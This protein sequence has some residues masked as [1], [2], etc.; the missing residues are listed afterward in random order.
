MKNFTLLLT[1]GLLWQSS[2]AQF[3]LGNELVSSPHNNWSNATAEYCGYQIDSLGNAPLFSNLTTQYDGNN[4]VVYRYLDYVDTS[5]TNGIGT[6]TIYDTREY[7][8]YNTNEDI[9]SYTYEYFDHNTSVWIMQFR[10]TY[11]Y[12]IVGNVTEIIYEDWFGGIYNYSAQKYIYT[13]DSGG[14]LLIT[15]KILQQW[16]IS[17]NSYVNDKKYT[18]TYNPSLVLL[19]DNE[20][21]WNSS[22]S[23]WPSSPWTQ[24]TYT[25]GT[26]TRLASKTIQ[27][28][29]GNLRQ[30]L[31]SYTPLGSLTE[32][33]SQEKISNVW[34]N[35]DRTLTPRDGSERISSYHRELWS[36]SNSAWDANGG[37]N[38]YTYNSNNSLIE[39]IS[40]NWINNSWNNSGRTTYTLDANE[41]V[42]R[43]DSYIW[44]TT[45][46]QWRK[47][48]FQVLCSLVTANP[49]VKSTASF[50]V[51][52]NPS[53]SQL[54]LTT[55][56]FGNYRLLSTSGQVVKEGFVNQQTTI[57]VQNLD[58]GFYLLEYSDPK[59]H[60]VKKII[61][62]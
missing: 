51:Y 39:E 29:F 43:D 34:T 7:Y 30:I 11:S 9:L 15:E 6:F 40:Q 24:Q 45:L 19:S 53:S 8:T 60:K 28:P 4:N 62:R 33:L 52:P 36:T 48:S 38:L 44:D 58:A 46:V 23:S 42:Q 3:G 27:Y 37:K 10:E 26:G 56:S 20:Y 25:Y 22:T 1:L 35:T 5:I 21:W 49:K 14:N 32:E 47:T 13:Y 41:H 16:D 54:T 61:I 12:D 59:I 55:P 18:Y 17:L 50:Q 31:Y 2:F 57:D